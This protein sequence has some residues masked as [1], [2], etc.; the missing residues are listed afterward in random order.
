M[1]DGTG[2]VMKRNLSLA[3]AALALLA[4]AGCDEPDDGAIH[5]YAEGQFRLLAPAASG[6]ILSLDVTEGQTV[7][8]GA[9]V[10]RLDDSVERAELAAAR[11]SAEAAAARLKDASLG[12]RT[13]EVEA[14]KEV[15]AQA[16][17]S[18]KRAAEDLE[19]IRPLYDRGIVPRAQLDAAEAA[20]SEADARV[21]E[22]RQRLTV[23]ELPARENV[24]RAL[25]ADLEA[26]RASVDASREALARRGVTVPEPG[27]VERVLRQPG[28]TAGP[29]APVIRYLPEGAMKA[30]GFVPEAELGGFS[31]GDRLSVDCDSCAPDLSAVV[32]SIAGEAAFT[33]PEI[34]SDKERARLVFRIEA[35]FEGAFPPSG[36]PLRMRRLP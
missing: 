28:E 22:L 3:A 13:P 34:F 20:A 11:A 31:L 36:T 4:L 33:S 35:R 26:A 21:A 23:T 12:A 2:M 27:R 24:I 9:T 14:A 7:K 30:V 17:A 18:A 19:R 10:A 29:A 1:R 32:T 5:G 8:T 25:E 16:R 6:R 15:L